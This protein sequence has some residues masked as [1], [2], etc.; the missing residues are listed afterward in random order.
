MAVPLEDLVTLGM[1]AVNIVLTLI[2]V[3][4]YMKNYKAVSSKL[5]LGLVSFAAMFLVEN[6]VDFYFFNSLLAKEFYGF[7]SVTFFVNFIEMIGLLLLLYVA[8]K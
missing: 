6:L 2:L 5:T 4:I 1:I 3:F 7:T 8:S